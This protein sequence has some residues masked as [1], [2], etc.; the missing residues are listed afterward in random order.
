[1]DQKNKTT[2]LFLSADP[3]DA[4]RLRLGQEQREIHEKLQLASMRDEFS[5]EVRSSVRPGDM[6]QALHDIKPRIVHFSGHGTKAGEICLENEF[7]KIHPVSSEALTSLFELVTSYVDCVILNACYSEAQA[8]AIAKHIDYVI[9]MSQAIGDGAAIAF[10][11]GFYRALGA[12]RTIED[13]FMFG[14]VELRLMNI[15]EHLTPVLIK[16][17]KSFTGVS[18]LP[19]KSPFR[20]PDAKAVDKSKAL[21]ARGISKILVVDDERDVRRNIEKTLEKEGYIVRTVRNGEQAQ[22]EMEENAFD[23]VVLDIIMPDLTGKLNKEAGLHVLQDIRNK[24]FNM[25]V[26]MLSANKNVKLAVEVIKY[27]ASDYFVKGDFNPEEFL[28]KI[29]EHLNIV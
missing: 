10:S 18:G 24:G 3:S 6:I 25:P 22:V 27:G 23:L 20:I 26:I 15:S 9:G 13:A 8:R 17:Q 14:V 12:G 7:G 5:L 16:K 29:R 4:T 28:K 21:Q 2:I 19:P 1:M 11:V